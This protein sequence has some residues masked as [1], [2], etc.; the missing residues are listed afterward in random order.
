M[1]VRNSRIASAAE[2]LQHQGRSHQQER[3][4]YHVRQQQQGC[5]QHFREPTIAGTPAKA[6]RQK[7]WKHLQQK[8]RQQQ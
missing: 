5:K 8:R 6:D 2:K 1:D 4:Q 7:H 3:W